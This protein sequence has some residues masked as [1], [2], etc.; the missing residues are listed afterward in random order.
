MSNSHLTHDIFFR[1]I[2]QKKM[3][4][5][6]NRAEP[7]FNILAT[8]I[9]NNLTSGVC[10]TNIGRDCSIYITF[11]NNDGGE[12]GHISLH[13][14]PSIRDRKNSE[15]GRLHAKNAR[16][17]NRRHTIRVN[18]SPGGNSMRLSIIHYPTVISK[19]FEPYINTTLNIL[20]EYL[21]VTSPKSLKYAFTTNHEAHECLDIIINQFKKTKSPLRTTLSRSRR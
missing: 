17:R 5:L 2:T 18:S 20:N 9:N 16:N 13:L 12:M 10:T 21:D 1:V 6:L 3:N 8:D 7:R 19:S 14:Y 15:I 4:E 11:Y